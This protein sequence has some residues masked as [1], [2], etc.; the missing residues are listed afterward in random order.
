GAAVPLAAAVVGTRIDL[1]PRAALRPRQRYTVERLYAYDAAGA[2]VGDAQRLGASPEGLRRAWFPAVG[3]VTAAGPGARVRPATLALTETRVDFRFGGGDCGP[4]LSV[5]TGFRL[6]PATRSTDSVQ[7][8]VRARGLAPR[9][10]ATIPADGA[11]S[12]GANDLLCTPDPV[13]IPFR[14][15]L[16]A[17]VV[18]LDAAGAAV[19]ASA[20]TAPAG[21][22]RM[23]IPSRWEASR[24]HQ[25]EADPDRERAWTAP[26]IVT[27]TAARTT[28]P[29]ACPYGFESVARQRVAAEGAPW[30]Y[31]D[32][33][34]LLFDGA[35]GW[36][37]LD[38]RRDGD[39]MNLLGLSPRGAPTTL[40]TGLSGGAEAA[41]LDAA[42]PLAVSRFFHPPAGATR[43]VTLWALDAD[44][45]TRWS[46]G[47]FG[48]G[49]G[50]R[51]AAGGGHAL[52]TFV[53]ATLAASAPLGWALF[54]ARTGAPQAEDHGATPAVTT[55]GS[56]AA[57][58]V[59]GRF[60]LAWT[61]PHPGDDRAPRVSVA[62]LAPDGT[63]GPPTELPV[64]AAGPI[65]LASVGG[66][67]ALVSTSRGRVEWTLLD[68]N[69]AVERGPVE[70][71]AG[72]GGD[73]H[74]KPRV[75]C[76]DGL[77]AVAW[78]SSSSDATW[79]VAVGLDGAV[80]PAHPLAGQGT[81]STAGIAAGAGR[82]F[83]ASYSVNYGEAWVT[84]LRCRASAAAGAPGRIGR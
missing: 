9:V 69:G 54:D 16:E 7:L 17:R 50:Y 67:A 11:T 81:S 79:S 29:S 22:P 72:V 60:V 73:D 62:T 38:A 76:R 74:R 83:L 68:R 27:P 63:L 65:D 3:F 13:V 56:A 14:P 32:Q 70:L 61:S 25:P 4:G 52:A 37:A 5:S 20:W 47:L 44:G 55:D 39:A 64:R 21:S 31:E 41:A 42:G 33:S 15:A 35:R 45:R 84:A 12:V 34:T 30:M 48:M 75:S 36:F 82:S 8:E 43:D 19:S 59:D 78:E 40:R 58:W 57:A 24:T 71:S 80:S 1:R 26:P 23:P 51:V 66:R 6:P 28:V 10:V 46:H 2:L 18:V 77:C 49:A 53:R